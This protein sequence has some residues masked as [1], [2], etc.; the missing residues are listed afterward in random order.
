MHCFKFLR[1]IGVILPAIFQASYSWK[2]ETN[3]LECECGS[4]LGETNP[5]VVFLDSIQRFCNG[6]RI[7][8]NHVLTSRSCYT[9]CKLNFTT[10]NVTYK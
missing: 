4:V 1:C 6:I 3:V 10:S 9:N 7:S 8:K 5:M 2:S